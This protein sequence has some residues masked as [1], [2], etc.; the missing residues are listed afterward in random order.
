MNNLDSIIKKNIKNLILEVENPRSFYDI[1]R[2]PDGTT[3]LLINGS[4]I[5]EYNE[6]D[7]RKQ[8][9]RLTDIEFE[10]LFKDP[11]YKN[12]KNSNNDVYA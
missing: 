7:K 11:N 9:E 4:K 1:K 8:I 3:I 6:N 12:Y 2:T 10:D 5:N